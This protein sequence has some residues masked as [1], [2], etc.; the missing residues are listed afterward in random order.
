MENRWGDLTVYCKYCDQPAD[1]I[2]PNGR[3]SSHRLMCTP[4]KSWRKWAESYGLPPTETAAEARRRFGVKQ[5]ADVP[6]EER[7]TFKKELQ[8]A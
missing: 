8:D 3:M 2:V 5:P 7:R 1:Y 4:C 6:V